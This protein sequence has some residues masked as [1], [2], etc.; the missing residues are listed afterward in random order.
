MNECSLEATEKAEGNNSGDDP[1][2]QKRGKPLN[3]QTSEVNGETN[4]LFSLS[5][6]FS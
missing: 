6:G 2:P 1:R 3:D 4:G 5:L